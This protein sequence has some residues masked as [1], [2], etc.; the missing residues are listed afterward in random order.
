[1]DLCQTWS[2][3]QTSFN[4]QSRHPVPTAQNLNQWLGANG[5]NVIDAMICCMCSLRQVNCG[6]FRQPWMLSTSINH[7]HNFPALDL[8]LR[9]CRLP[10]SKCCEGIWTLAKHSEIG[11]V[12]GNIMSVQ[13]GCT[14]TDR[15]PSQLV[16]VQRI[17][18]DL[19]C[20]RPLLAQVI[21]AV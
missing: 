12:A 18:I 15:Y 11:E 1:M 2:L 6:T 5:A 9:L 16:I 8:D 13:S 4:V 21:F 3:F 17:S 7:Q 20:H 14:Y 19:I 10:C